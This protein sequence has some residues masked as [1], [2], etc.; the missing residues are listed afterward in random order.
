MSAARSFGD[1]DGPNS[2]VSGLL[3]ERQSS[4]T[5]GTRHQAGRVL[6]PGQGMKAARKRAARHRQLP[7]QREGPAPP[8]GE[9]R[10]RP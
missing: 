5:R 1:V 10:A 3:A 8:E 4:D 7:Q 9:V 6:H 2:N